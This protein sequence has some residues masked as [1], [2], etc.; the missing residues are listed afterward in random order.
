M[1]K[2]H[3][4]LIL[5][6][7]LCIAI[8]A[9]WFCAKS[10]SNMYVD[11]NGNNIA[12]ALDISL[13]KKSSIN[14]VVPSEKITF[15][16]MNNGDLLAV[17]DNT[18]G[19]LGQ[20]D[21]QAYTY[22]VQVQL[23]ERVKLAAA[24]ETFAV[25]V[26]D[27]NNIYFWGQCPEW[28][29]QPV[30]PE[31]EAPEEDEAADEEAEET[32]APQPEKTEPPLYTM[33]PCSSIITQ[34]CLTPNHCAFLVKE[35]DV[36]TMGLNIGQLGYDNNEAHYGELYF[37]FRPIATADVI[38]AIAAS[39][40]A[41]YMIDMT[42]ILYGC[43]KNEQ[44]EVC[45]QE[46]IYDY[47]LISSENAFVKMTTAGSNLFA[48]T[49]NGDVYV[50]GSNAKGVL[51]VDSRELNISQLTKI[52]FGYAKISDIQGSRANRVFFLTDEGDVYACGDNRESMLYTKERG[53]VVAS[54]ALVRIDKASRLFCGG[55][56]V[57]Y[58][59]NGHLYVYGNNV[60]GQMPHV[61]AGET[62]VEPLRI[63]ASVK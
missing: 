24:C 58:M 6:L 51:G 34:I 2:K 9:L 1:L 41:T 46:N 5:S 57:Y 56:M 25:A 26:S 48:L 14:K 40:T 23:P 8:V 20:G 19:Q 60:Y 7:M 36:Y 62:F 30:Q 39:D 33:I 28:V 21:T 61:K 54:P 52:N 35:G 63:Y 27:S 15:F 3:I 11:E 32:E 47:V 43:S 16:V 42:G 49:T 12:E 31:E 18:Y 10:F 13:L 55:D 50:C 38:Y 29:P 37:S 44:H 17:G 59:N 22:P 45:L 53:D 4:K